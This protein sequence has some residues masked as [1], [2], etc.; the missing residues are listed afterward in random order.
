MATWAICVAKPSDIGGDDTGYI[1]P[2]LNVER[3]IVTA[4][5]TQTIEGMLFNTSG[6]SATNIHE[7]KRLTCEARIDKA[8]ELLGKRTGPCIIWVDT[9]YESDALLK[10][11]PHAVDVRGSHSAEEKEKRLLAFAKGEIAVMVSKSKIAGLGMNF[12]VCNRM[13]FAGLS[14]SFE[15]YFQS[16]RRCWRFGQKSPVHVDIVLA[17]SESAISSAIARKETDHELMQEG[18][19]KAMLT[20]T[21]AELEGDRVR[22]QFVPTQTMIIPSFLTTESQYV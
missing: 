1:L 11:L 16:V 10:A 12:Q 14:Y 17:D 19:A 8:V 15:A 20:A 13:I 6:L 18:M 3:H 2:P 9:N 4:K 22:S 7:E 5:E 21:L